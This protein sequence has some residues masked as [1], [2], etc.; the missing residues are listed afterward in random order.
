MTVRPRTARAR[1]LRRDATDA[2]RV[3]WRALRALELPVRIR[4]QHPIGSYIADFAIPAHGLV[5]E[6]DGGQHAD[7][8][9]ADARRT[10]ALD[11]HGYRVIRFWN[12][13]VLG[14]IEGV[15]ETILREIESSPPL[16]NPLRPPRGREGITNEIGTPSPPP[17]YLTSGGRGLG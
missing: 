14:N 17:L 5:I 1:T 10:A 15:V 3:L 8:A 2:E 11:E 12:N 16:P 9:D 6:I 7:A 4:R 13:E